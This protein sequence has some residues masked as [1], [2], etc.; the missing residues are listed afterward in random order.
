MNFIMRWGHHSVVAPLFKSAYQAAC[1]VIY[2]G[3]A[4]ELEDISMSGLV[5]YDCRPQPFLTA[6]AADAKEA[7]QA[8]EIS[9]Q[10]TKSKFPF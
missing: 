5:L 7:L 4:P 10:Y 3:L 8:W 6:S 2:A 9:E 1:T